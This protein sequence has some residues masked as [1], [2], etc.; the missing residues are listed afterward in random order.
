MEVLD[1]DG[2]AIPGLYAA[3]VCAGGLL[4]ENYNYDLPGSAQGFAVNSGRI[5]GESAAGYAARP[6]V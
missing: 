5:A 1:P 6:A 3:G 4:G 2:R